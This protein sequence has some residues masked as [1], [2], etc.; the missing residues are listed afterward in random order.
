M[1]RNLSIPLG[2]AMK[3]F[4]VGAALLG[5][6]TPAKATTIPID[7]VGFCPPPATAAS[8]TTGTGLGGETISVGATSI[9]MFK[10]GNGG[11]PVSPW[12]LLVAV[13]NDVGGAP[14]ISFSVGPFTQVGAVDDEGKFMPTT[15]GSIYDFADS[16]TGDSSMNASNMFGSNEVVARGSA[17]SFF[18][19]FAYAF[20]PEIANNTAYVITV[21]GAGLT[22]GTFLAAAGGDNPFSTPFTI[23]GLVGGNVTTQGSPVPEPASLALLGSGL[24]LAAS[25]LR[26]KRSK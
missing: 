10:N 18:E 19:I 14:A 22:A 26:K 13:P 20:Q 15:A 5:I 4:V 6:A 16:V 12:Q 8:C 7:P 9:G 25:R 3:L 23:T 1:Q 24:A 17:P 2:R 11:T 21:G